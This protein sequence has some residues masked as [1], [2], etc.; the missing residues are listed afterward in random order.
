MSWIGSLQVFLLLIFGSSTG[1]LVDQG[2][3]RILA[4]AG[5]GLLTLGLILTS[6]SGEF[7]AS[8]NETGKHPI[9][10]QVLLSQ[11]ILSGLGMGLLLVPSTAIVPT[12]FKEHRAF[13]VGM[14]NTGA[15]IGGI[16]YPI[17][18]RR[19]IAAVGF[20]WAVRAIALL[21][22]VT[23]VIGALL[24]AQRPELT[25]AP[26][27]RILWNL[28]CLTEISYALFAT[29]VL[30][31]FVGL[32]I[33]YFYVTAWARDASIPLHGLQDYYLLSL[34]NIGG[35]AGRVVPA[36]FADSSDFGAI[37]TQGLSAICCGALAAAW[38]SVR[39]SFGGLVVWLLAYGFFSGSV[40][41]L[42]PT[43]AAVLTPDL[44]LL[45]GRIGVVFAGNGF[46]SLIGSP[47]A[48]AI[49]Q[50]TSRG[51]TGLALYCATFTLAGG[52]LLVVCWVL[53]LRGRKNPPV[54]RPQ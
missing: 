12:Y 49:L 41:S 4:F 25:K 34:L 11:G 50:N 3:A 35:L 22:L 14:A 44:K 53:S 10:Y 2:H 7:A 46:A 29:G 42:I 31:S 8:S 28:Q 6:L 1:S 18:T 21:V 27:K 26:G 15:S 24:L 38:M 43:S 45:G 20:N 23:T 47:V 30:V 48:G 36:F 13:A 17:V 52:A 37:L 51:W 16:T 5:C 19:L 9:Y 33:P 32:Y 40:I 39:N 54:T